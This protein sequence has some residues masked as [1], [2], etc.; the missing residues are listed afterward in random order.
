MSEEPESQAD[1]DY[2]ARLRSSTDLIYDAASELSA[3]ANRLALGMPSN[4]GTQTHQTITFQA[5]TLAAIV[6]AA[7]GFIGIVVAVAAVLVVSARSDA[8]RQAIEQL[9]HEIQKV[10]DDVETHWSVI[11]NHDGKIMKLEA[12]NEQRSP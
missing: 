9:R 6:V 11:R 3:A 5:G 4:S 2:A 10:G 1:D 8:D 7:V 12:R